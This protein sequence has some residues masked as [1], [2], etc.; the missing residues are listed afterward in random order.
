MQPLREA[1]AILRRHAAARHFCSRFSRRIIRRLRPSGGHYWFFA[2]PFTPPLCRAAMVEPLSLVNS[3]DTYYNT[4]M[5]MRVHHH[6]FTSARVREEAP[7]SITSHQLLLMSAAMRYRRHNTTMN[8]NSLYTVSRK[9]CAATSRTRLHARHRGTVTSRHAMHGVIFAR[10][11]RDETMLRE[12]A[13]VQCERCRRRCFASTLAATL[14][15]VS[16]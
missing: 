14:R 3:A 4:G 7:Q 16:Q 5:A 8:I 9:R 6:N 10:L 1:Y 15:C 2:T 12:A 13:G 11:C